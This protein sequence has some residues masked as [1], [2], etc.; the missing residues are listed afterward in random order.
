MGHASTLYESGHIIKY[1]G[2][3]LDVGPD[4]LMGQSSPVGCKVKRIDQHKL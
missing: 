4:Q 3:Q 2:H 1:E